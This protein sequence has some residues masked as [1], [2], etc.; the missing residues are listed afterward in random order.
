MSS[1][2]LDTT[3]ANCR[4][5]LIRDRRVLSVWNVGWTPKNAKKEGLQSET[6]SVYGRTA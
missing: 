5:I 3:L 1:Y 4:D 6:A 2:L